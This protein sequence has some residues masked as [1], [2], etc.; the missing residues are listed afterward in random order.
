MRNDLRLDT[1]VCLFG[2]EKGASHSKQ[3]EIKEGTW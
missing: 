1:F 3:Q 2:E